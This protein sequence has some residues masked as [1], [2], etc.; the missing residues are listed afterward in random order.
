[1][2]TNISTKP[3]TCHVLLE[4]WHGIKNVFIGS[5]A[6][7]KCQ[8]LGVPQG[9]SFFYGDEDIPC[10][11]FF[12]LCNRSVFLLGHEVIICNSNVD[13]YVFVSIRWFYRF[14]DKSRTSLF[15]TNSS[16]Q[17]VHHIFISSSIS[18]AAASLHEH[19]SMHEHIIHHI[20]AAA[21]ARRSSLLH[22]QHIS[23]PGKHIKLQ[24]Q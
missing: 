24:Y 11:A 5:S 20:H 18:A 13:H 16:R 14:E 4:V 19:T 12:V 15:S 23:S 2:A 22:V 1:M 8:I 7:G 3:W 9:L 21:K 17:E 10:A 6:S